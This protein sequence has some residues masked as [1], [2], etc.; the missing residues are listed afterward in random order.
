MALFKRIGLFL[1][2][3]IAVIFLFSLA[4]YAINIIFG[5]DI[6]AMSGQSYIG[7]LIYA[8]LFGFIGSFFSLSISRWMAKRAYRISP[9]TQDDIASLS[10]KEKLVYD[11][12]LRISQDHGIKTPE[13]GIY[14][15]IDPN[16]FAT[17]PSKNKS[18]VAVSTG[19]LQHMNND[20]IEGVVAHEMAHI[21]NGDMV[22]MTLLQGVMNTF[23]IFFSRILAQVVNNF[24]DGK[25]GGI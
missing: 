7:L 19:L 1:L 20:E 22:N 8:A 24:T 17:G 21:L 4:I 2:T 18:L 10:G 12:V 13:V 3:N 11:T 15:S 9:F 16:A 6:I 23:V 14:D 5:I 25:L